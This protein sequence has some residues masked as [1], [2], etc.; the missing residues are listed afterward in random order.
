MGLLILGYGMLAVACCK[1]ALTGYR[2]LACRS[3]GFGF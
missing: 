3:S 1:V 2:F